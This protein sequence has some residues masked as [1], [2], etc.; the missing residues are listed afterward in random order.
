LNRFLTA[1]FV[2]ILGILLLRILGAERLVLIERKLASITSRH[3]MPCRT[4]HT[5]GGLIAPCR[6]NRNS[7]P[8]LL[9]INET[10]RGRG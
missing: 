6:N 2:F 1:D 10:R 7:F 9:E 3:G 5:N 4:A 8:G